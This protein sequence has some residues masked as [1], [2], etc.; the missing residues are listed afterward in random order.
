[1]WG[2]G[3]GRVELETLDWKSTGQ[4]ELE[5]ELLGTLPLPSGN[6]S[7]QMSKKI[8]VDCSAASLGVCTA[9]IARAAP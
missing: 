7:I 5:V 2:W 3:G 1:M 6:L 8:D 4:D 9:V